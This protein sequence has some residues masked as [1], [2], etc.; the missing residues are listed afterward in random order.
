MSK[1]IDD[2]RNV[3]NFLANH[4]L[5]TPEIRQTVNQEIDRMSKG[6]AAQKSAA[7]ELTR[8]ISYPGSKEA[9]EMM[10]LFLEMTRTNEGAKIAGLPIG[11]RGK[12]YTTKGVKRADRIMQVLVDFEVGAATE[13]EVI[14]AARE[15]NGLDCDDRT[16]KKFIEALRP[17]A[18]AE[19]TL[20]KLV[21]QN[22]K[23]QQLG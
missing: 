21:F 8:L 9:R 11:V 6:S 10:Q 22:P 12:S 2:L 7:A 17:R 13:Q 18:V 23:T 4:Q 3:L 16:I 1:K 20:F 14:D 19:A 5:T 15:Y